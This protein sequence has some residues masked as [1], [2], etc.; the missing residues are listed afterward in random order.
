M[1]VRN[2]NL[3]D[4]KEYEDN[5]GANILNF[6]NDISFTNLIELVKLGN[7][8]CDDEVA[9]KIVDDYLSIPDNTLLSGILEIKEKLLGYGNNNEIDE[10]SEDT[11]D[12]TKYNSLTELYM[13][14]NM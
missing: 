2:F 13:H 6:F 12:I 10:N 8:K 11:V 14:F 3:K 1:L 5:T 4:I 9:C 7:G